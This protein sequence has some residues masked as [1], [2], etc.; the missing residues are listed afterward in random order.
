M[1]RNVENLEISL[2]NNKEIVFI[3]DLNKNVTKTEVKNLTKD[4]SYDSDETKKEISAVDDD[5]NDSITT[6]NKVDNENTQTS[7]EESESETDLESTSE[8]E[9]LTES[10]S[11]SVTESESE[12]TSEGSI[13]DSYVQ[14]DAEDKVSEK[15]TIEENEK[16]SLGKRNTNNNK[17][18]FS[19]KIDTLSVN[20]QPNKSQPINSASSTGS[21]FSNFVPNFTSLINT[22]K[23]IRSFSSLYFNRISHISN[24]EVLDSPLHTPADYEDDGVA[25]LLA[26]L[27]EQNKLLQNDPKNSNFDT[28]NVSDVREFWDKVIVDYEGVARKQPELLA[29]KIRQGI[30]DS[31]RRLIWQSISKSKSSDLE[32]IYDKL[33]KENTPYEKIIRRDLSR[34]FPDHDYFKDSNGEGQESLFNVMKVYSLYDKDLGYCQ[35]L[36][37][38]VGPLL[39]KMPDKEAFCVLVRLLEEYNMRGLYT[40]NMEGLQLRLYQFDHLLYDILPKVARHLENE[41]IRSTMYASQWFMTLFAYKFPLELVFRILDVLFAEGFV[42]IFKIAFALLKKNQDFILEFEFESLIDFLKNGLFDIYY[43]DIS[44][45]IKDAFEIKISKRR[46]DKL[47][48]HFIQE[49]KVLDDNNQKVEFFKKE[50]KDLINEMQKLRATEEFLIH[51]KA[52]L[53][54]ELDDCR[55]EQTANKSLIEALQ[56]QA[57]ESDKLVAHTLRDAKKQA[58]EQLK[59]EMEVLAKKSVDKTLK[60]KKLESRIEELEKQVAEMKMKYAQSENEKNNFKHKWENLKKFID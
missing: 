59:V 57:E 54:N 58:E 45:L 18:K 4:K 35:G 49:N 29:E 32:E 5:C 33:L 36:S 2:N 19:L 43:D 44:E 46:L 10:E 31:L 1:E 38:I 28:S 23:N 30:P 7:S 14:V 12:S 41:G 42:S 56:K 9:S 34:T 20:G 50:N 8:L 3:K 39:L 25:F 47:T 15:I 51:E 6:L 55:V 52:R 37:F 26:R 48:N 13:D 27:E 16:L 40:P 60:N 53:K 21:R 11:E 24:S 17:K 22:T